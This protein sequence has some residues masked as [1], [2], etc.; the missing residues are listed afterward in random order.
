MAGS[1]KVA[2]HSGKFVAGA[3]LEFQAASESMVAQ[4]F[5]RR[6]TLTETDLGASIPDSS[7]RV[8]LPYIPPY[9]H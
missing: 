3:G 9:I 6:F 2:S 1:G 8:R 4:R 5:L 7:S